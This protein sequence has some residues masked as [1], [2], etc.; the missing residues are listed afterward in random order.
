LFDIFQLSPGT[1][2]VMAVCGSSMSSGPHKAIS[3]TSL[4]ARFP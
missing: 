4:G 2:T 3:F 1:M